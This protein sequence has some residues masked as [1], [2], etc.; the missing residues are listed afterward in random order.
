M[1]NLGAPPNANTGNGAG[2]GAGSGAGNQ[3]ISKTIAQV[4]LRK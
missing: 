1:S 4:K 2:N 3:S